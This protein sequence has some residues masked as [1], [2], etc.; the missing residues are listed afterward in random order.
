LKEGEK[1][2]PHWF[3]YNLRHS[4]GTE[5]TKAEGKEKARHL[6]THASP[7]TTDIYDNSGLEVRQE[8]ARRR[9]NPF[10]TE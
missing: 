9:V 1:P 10:E 3:P 5:T 6:L 2:V 8:L 4:A 7:L